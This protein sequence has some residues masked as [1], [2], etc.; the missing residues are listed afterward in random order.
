MTAT[1]A[2]LNS[3]TINTMT[4]T[5]ATI[6][7]ATITD[8]KLYGTITGNNWNITPG[9]VATFGNWSFNGS[10]MSNNGN[11]ISLRNGSLTLD[12]NGALN[13]FATAI[14]A[15]AAG[16]ASFSDI[17]VMGSIDNTELN[18]TLNNH[19]GRL[20]ALENE[21]VAARARI[22][23]LESDLEDALEDAEYWED[24]Y[25]SHECP[26]PDSGGNSGGS[27]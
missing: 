10:V 19:E 1:S 12:A 6:T 20:Q 4:A 21:L 16:T 7:T 5:N 14:A 2:T 11:S 26:E 27:E 9:G 13:I 22:K 24:R 15:G 17:I 25:N 8:V 18:N 23:E 3:A